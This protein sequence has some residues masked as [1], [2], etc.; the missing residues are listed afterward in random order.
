MVGEVLI[1]NELTVIY[2]E[3]IK[4]KKN[5]FQLP[6]GSS[7]EKF[8]KEL[9]RLIYLFVNKTAWEKVALQMIHVFIPLMLQKPSLKSKARDHSKYLLTRLQRWKD[10][11]L[12]SLME[13]NTRIEQFSSRSNSRSVKKLNPN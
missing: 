1:K 10:G 4:W 9:T 5:L 2:D 12:K 11:D 3:I 13:Q 8:I 6:R 7:A